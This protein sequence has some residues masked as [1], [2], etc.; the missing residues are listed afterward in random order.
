[1]ML[2]GLQIGVEMKKLYSK[3]EGIE[4]GCYSINSQGEY[5]YLKT[6]THHNYHTSTLMVDQ[7]KFDESNKKYLE[8]LKNNT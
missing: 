5:I 2:I 3:R 6:N 1:M 7:R 4:C 8:D